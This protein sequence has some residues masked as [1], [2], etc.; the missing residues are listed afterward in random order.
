M[1]NLQL[2]Q[3]NK[4]HS[5]WWHLNNKRQYL[6]TVIYKNV[7]HFY[8]AGIKIIEYDNSEQSFSYQKILNHN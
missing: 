2:L 7:M 3:K 5:S 8:Q 1:D 6:D 4:M